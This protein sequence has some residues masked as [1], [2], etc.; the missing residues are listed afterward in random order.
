MGM[1]DPIVGFFSGKKKDTSGGAKIIKNQITLQFYRANVDT[2]NMTGLLN[3]TKASLNQIKQNKQIDNF[4]IDSNQ[5]RGGGPALVVTI[6]TDSS[7]Q[8]AA[9]ASMNKLEFEGPEKL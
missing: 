6:F 7:R 5:Q 2:A 4:T 8:N 9:I 3:T 1:F